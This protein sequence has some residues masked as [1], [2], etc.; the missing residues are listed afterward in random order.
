MGSIGYKAISIIKGEADLYISYAEK[1]KSCP[2]DWDMAA[3]QSIIKGC[4]GYF[5]DD[6]G[7]DL[8]FL[9]D[10][11]FRQ[12]GLILASMSQNHLEIYKTIRDLLNS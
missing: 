3:P 1:S 5:T 7:Y 6:K 4:K 2:K 9:N 12:E 8:K 11:D 10:D